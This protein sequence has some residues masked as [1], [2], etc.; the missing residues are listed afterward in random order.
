VEIQGILKFLNS[1]YKTTDPIKTDFLEELFVHGLCS[2]PALECA[3]H[4]S[5]FTYKFSAFHCDCS[6][7]VN[8]PPVAVTCLN[9]NIS[10]EQNASIFRVIKLVELNAKV[11][12]TK[13]CVGYIR[14]V[15]DV[16]PMT[17]TEC[18]MRGIGF[19]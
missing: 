12:Q 19:C 4:Y 5:S 18:R 3:V 14:W 6:S 15:E 17:A 7:S 11:I 8:F 13:K 16:W 10:E 9:V 1:K 2:Y